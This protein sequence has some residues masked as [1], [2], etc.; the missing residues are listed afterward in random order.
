MSGDLSGTTGHNTIQ[1]R[2]IETRGDGTII[3]GTPETYGIEVEA[4]RRRHD[5]NIYAWRKWV[6]EQMK[7]KHVI[8][9]AANQ[10][11]LKWRDQKIELE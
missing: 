5:G 4:L 9:M 11:V 7:A 3:Q 8:R 6:G 10:E 2:I 1:C